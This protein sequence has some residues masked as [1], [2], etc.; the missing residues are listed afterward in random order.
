[1]LSNG[2]LYFYGYKSPL[3]I[4]GVFLSSPWYKRVCSSQLCYIF[5]AMRSFLFLLNFQ[6]RNRPGAIMFVHDMANYI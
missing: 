6:L 3:F 2:S 1:M 5:L 4:V